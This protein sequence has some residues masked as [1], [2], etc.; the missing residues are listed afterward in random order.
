MSKPRLFVSAGQRIGRGEVVDPEIRVGV[1]PDRPQGRRGARL[2]CDCGNLYEVPLL[3]LVER[4]GR[5]NTSSCGCALKDHIR[6]V[7]FRGGR[8][9]GHGLSDH[10]LYGTWTAM[11][12]RCENPA[13]PRFA[14]YGGRGIQVCDRWQDIAQFIQDIETEIGPHPGRGWSLDRYPDVDG[15]YEPGNVRW[16]TYS[17]QNRN[18]QPRNGRFKGVSRIKESRYQGRTVS[19]AARV[20]LG[21]FATE[22]EAAEVYQRAVAV[23][24]KAGVLK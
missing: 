14:H 1:T 13:N 16:A 6:Q 24:E 23:L 11:R 22:E 18:R 15:N 3:S 19:W 21:H 4:N 20:H 10:P 17:Q 9:G 12:H 8:K 7:A 2:R 5:I